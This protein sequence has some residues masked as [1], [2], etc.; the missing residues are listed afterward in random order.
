[1]PRFNAIIFDMDGVIADSEPRYYAAVNTILSEDGVRLTEEEY[2]GVIGLSVE[3][4]WEEYIRRHGL[5]RPLAEYVR[6]YDPAVL[7]ELRKP[8][9]PSPGVREL[10][11]A[12]KKRGL[13]LGLASSSLG[14]WVEALL[15]GIGLI[16]A[17]EV[18][19]YGEM[20]ERHKP[21]PDCYL[22]A[23][24]RL[25]VR[26]HRCLAIEDSP[27]GIQSANAAG[28]FVVAVRTPSTSGLDLSLADLV[29]E[30]LVDFDPSLLD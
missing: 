21:A 22:L 6:L 12:A 13:R 24:E 27:S 10:I 11:E 1:M 18:V 14:A 15:Q 17:F 30:T 7:N 19:V 29:L 28:M 4:A 5:K 8:A 26:P 9:E 3:A 25:G 16:D 20:V 2:A 23:A